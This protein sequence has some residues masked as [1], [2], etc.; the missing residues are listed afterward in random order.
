M[1]MDDDPAPPG[2]PRLHSL[3]ALRGFDMVWIIGGAAILRSL[4][5]GVNCPTLRWMAAETHHAPWHGFRFYDLIFPLFL[6]IAGVAMAYSLHGRRE[7]GQDRAG[8]HWRVLRRGLALVL[9]GLIYNGMLGFDFETLRWPSVLGRIG[10]AYLFAGLIVLHT[11]PRGQVVWMVALLIGYWVLLTFI[12]V[13]GFEAG[14]LT[15]GATLA[16][17]LDRQ[18]LPGRLYHGDRD[19]EGLLATIPAISTA[20]LGVLAGQFLR[21]SRWGGLRKGG[22]LLAAGVICLGVARLWDPWFPINKNL[23]TGSFVLHCGGWSLL[24]LGMFYLVIDVWGLRKPAL[25]FAVIGANPLTIYIGQK[26]IDFHFTTNR[27]FHGVLSLF[28]DAWRPVV[29]ACLVLL[30][31]WLLLWV[32]YRKRIYLR[33]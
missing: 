16:D 21:S 29:L 20:L 10:L 25:V 3:D 30:V 22:A 14:S 18:F 32:L 28:S 11:G 7:R 8:L 12:P 9:L 24:L 6:F 2:P 19:P 13:P 27:V 23:W 17:Y 1:A 15:P 5:K 26:F 4:A 31:K 33:V